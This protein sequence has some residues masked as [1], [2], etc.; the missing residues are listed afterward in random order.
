[1][2]VWNEVRV[3]SRVAAA[4]VFPPRA[5]PRCG[6]SKLDVFPPGSA[7]TVFLDALGGRVVRCHTCQQAFITWRSRRRSKR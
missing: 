3:V 2:T 6:G 7:S 1:M 4:V 5:C